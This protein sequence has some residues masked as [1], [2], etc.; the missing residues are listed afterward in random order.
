MIQLLAQLFICQAALWTSPLVLDSNNV[1]DGTIETTC[2]AKAVKHGTISDLYEAIDEEIHKTAKVTREHKDIT[3]EGHTGK[4]HEAEWKLVKGGETLSM[5][6]YLSIYQSADEFI[7]DAQSKEITGTGPAKNIQELHPS[8][9]V[10]KDG[11]GYRVHFRTR[12]VIEKPNAVPKKKF[13]EIV[14]REAEAEQ[15]QS[16]GEWILKVQETL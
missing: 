7:F 3:P 16:Q 15:K 11:D 10:T 6:G 5:K 1:A 9:V 2:A 14:K 13:L 12:M 8:M 4:I